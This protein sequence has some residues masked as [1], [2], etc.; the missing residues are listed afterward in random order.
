MTGLASFLR[1]RR[2]GVRL[3]SGAPIFQALSGTRRRPRLGKG[4]HSR[5]SVSRPRFDLCFSRPIRL[6]KSEFA[7]DYAGAL[8]ANLGDRQARIIFGQARDEFLDHCMRGLLALIGTQDLKDEPHIIIRAVV[9]KCGEFLCQ[10]LRKSR[11]HRA[12]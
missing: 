12:E 2:L 8:K 6:D 10:V 5:A 7:A 4:F 9:G 11:E 3:L 1:I